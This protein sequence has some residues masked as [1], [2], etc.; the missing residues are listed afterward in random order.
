MNLKG[1]T[2]VLGVSGGIAAYKAC[3]ICS[4]LTQLGATVKVILTASATKFVQPLTFQ[5]LSRQA[6][7]VDTFAEEH[8]EV[9]S[10]IDLADHADLFLVAPATA[11]VIGKLAHGIADDMLTT[12]LLATRAPIWIAPAMN[13]N[14]LAHQAVQD[15]MRTLRNRGVRFIEPGEGL[16]ACGYVGQGRLSEPEQIIE[17]VLLYFSAPKLPEQ[18]WWRGKN[19]VITAGPTREEI[20]PVR[21]ISNHSSGKMGYAIAEQAAGLGA[22]VTLVS[23]PVSLS[24]PSQVN[25]IQVQSSEEMLQAVLKQYDQADVV[26]KAAA[27]ADYRPTEVASQKLKKKDDILTLTLEKTTD[28]LHHLGQIKKEQILVGFAAETNQVDEYAQQKLK[29]KNA[30]FI[31][32]NDVTK[33]GAGFGTDTNIVTIFHSSGQQISLPM[34][35]KK[36]LGLKI[37]EVVAKQYV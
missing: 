1:K 5:I 9:V 20:D 3:T 35:S 7:Y 27:V 18:E 4:Q 34:L 6:V 37:L 11:N 16:L 10:H 36:E 33:E 2:I 30:D 17:Q 22:N 29:R 8:P 31:V 15:N 14:M 24:A 21:Y 25:L 23:G 32:A 28:I 19:V 26:I 12:T 13:G